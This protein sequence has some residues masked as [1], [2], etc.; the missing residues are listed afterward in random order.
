MEVKILVMSLSSLL[1]PPMLV[2]AAVG[3]LQERMLI[4]RI[5]KR[6]TYLGHVNQERSLG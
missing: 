5:K 4:I 3:C 6:Q 2:N 1:V